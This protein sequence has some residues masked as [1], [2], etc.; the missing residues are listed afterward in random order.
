MNENMM[1]PRLQDQVRGT[2][3]IVGSDAVVR[4]SILNSLIDVST[5]HE[6]NEIVLPS[7]E[8]AYIYKDK[9]GEEVLSQ[10]Y[11]FPDRAN[12]LLCLRPEGT[13]TCQLLADQLRYAKDVKLWYETRCWRYE[14]PQAGR[15]REFTQFGLEILNPTKDYTDFMISVASEMVGLFTN[16]YEVNTLAKRGLAYYENNTG[17]EISCP[18]LGA[19]KQVVGGGKYDQGIGFAVGVD[20][21]MLIGR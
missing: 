14:R 6:F 13:A 19:Q 8:F 7:L 3:L 16:D 18:A 4:R 12:R 9:A 5:Y 21:I 20:R 1:P 2:R 10:M 15:Y 11:T 17:F